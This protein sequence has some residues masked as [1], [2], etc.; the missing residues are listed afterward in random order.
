MALIVLG[1][2]AVIAVLLLVAGGAK[3]ADPAGFAA[4]LGGFAARQRRP[5]FEA[6]SQPVL[7]AAAVGLALG[8]AGLGAASLS[9]PQDGWLNPVVLAVCCGFAAV[10]AAGYAWH[11]GRPCRCFG[12]LSLRSFNLAGL[13]RAVALAG[14]AAVAALPVRPALAQLSQAGRLGVLAGAVLVAWAAW[15]AA[16]AIGASGD[17]AAGWE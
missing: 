11:D 10:A 13:I 9:S 6:A 2:K 8:E 12:A 17:A 4:A 16:A 5:A 1:D 14:C 15:A 7:R 3:L